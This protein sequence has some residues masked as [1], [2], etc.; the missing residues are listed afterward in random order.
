M[1]S[2]C[3]RP[4]IWGY[5]SGVA[6]K[7]EELVLKIFTAMDLTVH[8]NVM[9]TFKMEKVEKRIKANPQARVQKTGYH[10]FAYDNI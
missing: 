10:S 1:D 8:P 3:G 6:A 4:M 9:G 7:G 5:S 2:I